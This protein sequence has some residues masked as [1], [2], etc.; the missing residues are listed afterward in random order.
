MAKGPL[1]ACSVLTA[2]GYWNDYQTPYLYLPE[3]YQTLAVGLR[4]FQNAHDENK[5]IVFA[6]ILVSILPVL[7]LYLIFQKRIIKSTN[8]G[9]LKG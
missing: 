3:D 2:I 5:P 8:A 4:L 1:I 7:I 6:A 9:G